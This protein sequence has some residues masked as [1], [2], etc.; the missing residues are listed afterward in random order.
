MIQFKNNHLN[1]LERSGKLVRKEDSLPG[2]IVLEV[3]N[4]KTYYPVTGG[5]FRRIV[6]YNKAVDDVSFNLKKG[7]ILGLVGESGCGK[8]S[9]GRTLIGLHKPAGGDIFLHQE[10]E[11]ADSTFCPVKVDLPKLS[12]GQIRPYRA[13]LQM[14]FQDPY[15]SLNPRYTVGDIIEEPLRIHS[16]KPRE[17]HRELIISLL[18]K[19]GLKENHIY[20]YPH[21]FSGGQRQRIG[22]ARALATSPEVI[23]ADEPVSA[24]DVSVQAQVINLMQDLQEEFK[25]SYIFI[26]HDLSVVKHISHTIAVMYLGSI[27][28]IG[29]AEEVYHN[30]IHPYTKALL[31]AV[32]KPDPRNKTKRQVLT[33]DV[34]SSINKPR[35]CSFHTRCPVKKDICLKE[36]PALRE[37]KEGQSAACHLL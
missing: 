28:E 34:P 19:V 35:G 18:G 15:S 21:E 26:A 8:S 2:D 9:V 5:V 1:K 31:S 4:L 37:I 17:E 22:I 13:A 14:I 3:Q 27:M 12:R 11:L 10:S 7:E 20:R 25:M 36:R 32:P 30:P 16:S 6:A 24:L 33:G 29:S 23:I